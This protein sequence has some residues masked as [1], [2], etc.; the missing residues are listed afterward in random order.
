MRTWRLASHSQKHFQQGQLTDITSDPYE[1]E[2]RFLP[3]NYVRVE[4]EGIISGLE[5]EFSD[6]SNGMRA[7][8]SDDQRWVFQL[9]TRT[10]KYD[11]PDDISA[12][13]IMATAGP[14]FIVLACD[15]YR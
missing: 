4:A 12:C 14:N 3:G 1:I 15:P 8:V 5:A 13:V 6:E 9:V 7:Y 10:G 2:V 11:S